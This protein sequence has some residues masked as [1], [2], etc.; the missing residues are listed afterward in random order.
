MLPFVLQFDILCVC[1]SVRVRVG[2][3]FVGE[4]GDQREHFEYGGVVVAW[5]QGGLLQKKKLPE[6]HL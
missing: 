2:I 1:F 6:T 3:D 5:A 4:V